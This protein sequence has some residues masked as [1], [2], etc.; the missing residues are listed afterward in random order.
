MTSALPPTAPAAS[1]EA[2]TRHEGVQA[3]AILVEAEADVDALLQHLSTRLQRAG[4]RVQGLL[5]T[6]PAGRHGCAG[7]M[8]LVDIRTEDTYLVS[9]SLGAGSRA[10]RADTQGFARASRVLRAALQD[11]PDLVICN[12]FGGLESEGGGF[13]AE[14][15]ALMAA[16]VPV[17]TAVAPRHLEAW[18]AFTGGAPT[19][20]ADASS[21]DTWLSQCLPAGGP[22]APATA[23]R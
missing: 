20:A 6:W 11:P 19:L 3:A 23:P 8:V 18:Q 12:R 2:L 1:C 10:C 14:L 15:L 22:S 13:A 21:V 17:L 5:M 4:W 16:G 7:E 9:Q